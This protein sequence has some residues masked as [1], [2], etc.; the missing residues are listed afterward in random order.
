MIKEVIDMGENVSNFVSDEESINSLT[1]YKKREIAVERSRDLKKC[2]IF[3]DNVLAMKILTNGLSYSLAVLPDVYT[4]TDWKDIINKNT[5]HFKV[6]GD[7]HL[8]VTFSANKGVALAEII[9]AVSDT[10]KNLNV[11]GYVE[12]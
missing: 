1:A 7:T 2:N 9:D 11:Y 10:L 4:F 5:V 3:V 6:S 12:D 8:T